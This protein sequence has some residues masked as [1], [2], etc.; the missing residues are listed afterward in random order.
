VITAADIKTRFPEFA[1]V[2]D[3]RIEFF[4]TDAVN[5]LNE[6][7][8]GR[9]YNKLLSLLVAHWLT[10]SAETETGLKR[11]RGLVLSESQGEK[12]TSFGSFAAKNL[13][14]FYFQQT[15]YGTEF[16]IFRSFV[17]GGGTIV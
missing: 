6:S 13:S 5:Y 17:A 4:I 9:F 8:A 11:G 12:S 1:N 2:V 10:L 15:A 7:R 16:L 14:E 3:S